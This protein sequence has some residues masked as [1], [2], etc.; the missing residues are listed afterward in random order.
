MNFVIAADR[1]RYPVASP[2]PA[3]SRYRYAKRRYRILFRLL[4]ALCWPAFQLVRGM[5]ARRPA[6]EPRS[7]LIVQLNHIGDAVLSTPMLRALRERFPKASIDVLA[8]HSNREIFETC[9]HVRRVHVSKGN[10]LSRE[11]STRSYFGAAFG[12]A[13]GMRPFRY[14]LGIDPRGDFLVALLLWLANIPRRLGWACGGGGFLL[15][16][17]ASWEPSRH[18]VESRRALV[19]PLGIRAACTQPELFPSWADRYHVRESLAAVPDLLLPLMVVHVGAGTKAKR[20]PMNHLAELIERLVRELVGSVILVGDSSDQELG[21]T[22]ARACPPAIDWTGSL[23]LMQM[24]ALFGEA[25]LFIGNDSGPAHIA[26]AMG[27]PSVVLFSGTNCVEC[28]RPVGTEVHVLRRSVPCSPCHL[29][30]CPVARHPCM[31]EISPAE[32]FEVARQIVK[33]PTKRQ[34]CSMPMSAIE[35]EADLD[36]SA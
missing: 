22:L 21:R 29:K 11:P 12:L 18:E 6:T 2:I 1:L 13:R 25:D 4:D 10:W 33:D 20:W 16:D 15:T 27:A 8:S 26:A 7:I 9:P 30:E 32:V 36:Q 24:A 17:V 5:N 23:T 35:L 28:W 14:D 31:S 3:G 19:E 34:R